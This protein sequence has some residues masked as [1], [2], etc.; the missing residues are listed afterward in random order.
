MAKKFRSKLLVIDETV[1]FL[2]GYEVMGMILDFKNGKIRIADKWEE[3]QR[4]TSGHL[5]W[6]Q[7]NM[8]WETDD[9]INTEFL[10]GEF[11]DEKTV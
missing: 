11:Q 10:V 9:K 2:F 3:M 6:S 4:S 8:K 5:L 1:P 7:L